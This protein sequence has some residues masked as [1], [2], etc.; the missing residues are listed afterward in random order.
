MSHF[1]LSASILSADFTR[2]GEEVANMLAAGV[3]QIHIDV[4][5]NHYVPNLTF[6]PIVCQALRK[7]GILAPFDVHLMVKPVDDLI[8][9]FAQ[10]GATSITF[11][12]EA[13]DHI[14]R[15]LQLIRSQGCRAGL[16]FNPATS[17]HYLEYI[18][19]KLDLIL[20]M[21][22]NPG[23]GGQQF[24]SESLQK[25]RQVRQLIVRQNLCIQLSVDGGIKKENIKKIAEAG[26]DTFVIGS[27]LF[28]SA[29]Y[30]TTV[31]AIREELA[32][33]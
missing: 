5:D 29:H 33:A 10:A 31:T 9:A 25:I 4:M 26:A 14:D 27:A 1:T 19:N 3:D 28:E 30:A 16:A 20:V 18:L 6:G 21:S 7:A 8:I 17:L 32:N 2:L 23:F 11:H 12:P 13:S 15:S 24:I 22:V